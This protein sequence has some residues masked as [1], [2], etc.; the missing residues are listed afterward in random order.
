MDLASSVDV[1]SADAAVVDRAYD[2]FEMMVRCRETELAI[3]RLHRAAKIAGSFHSSMGH[4]G[5]AVGVCSALEPDDIVT[6]T[7]RG[8][9]HAIA[10]GVPIAD[11]LAELSGSPTGVSK[12]KGGSMHLH[13][14]PTGFL[15]SNAIV[16]GAMPWAAGAAWAARQLGRA[17]VGVAFFGDGAASHGT[18]YETLRVAKV[19]EAPCL[20]VCENNGLAHS[21]PSERVFGADGAISELAR[22]VG[23]QAHHLGGSD[24]QEVAEVAAAA[25]D[26]A[27]EG[28]PQFLEIRVT[29]ARA[30]SLN[31]PEYRYRD[32]DAGLVELAETDPIARSE[33][34]LRSIDAE[35]VDRVLASVEHEVAAAVGA[36]ADLPSQDV[37]AAM[38]DID[39]GTRVH[40]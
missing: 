6:T 20:F 32:K 8:H 18:F 12:G 16:A 19:L 37:S 40:A 3:E 11:I 29:R 17:K 22:A 24:V 36:L 14:R 7:H 10:N 28:R 26:R 27:R 23:L 30:H 38:T 33:K 13:H 9:A 4:E 5:A 2:L 21:M 31:D 1:Q 35:R 25:L 34:H 39:D 15:G